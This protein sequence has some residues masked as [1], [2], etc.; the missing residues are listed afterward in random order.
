MSS[1]G[2]LQSSLPCIS[3]RGIGDFPAPL[4][5]RGIEGIVLVLCLFIFMPVGVY[6]TDC[7]VGIMFPV[8]LIGAHPT[9]MIVFGCVRWKLPHGV[10][11]VQT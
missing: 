6:Q 3:Q 7:R 11:V 2:Q 9:Y 1:T 10:K 4:V 5:R 8:F